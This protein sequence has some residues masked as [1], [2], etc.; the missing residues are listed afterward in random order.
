MKAF[1]RALAGVL[2]AA[3]LLGLSGGALAAGRSGDFTLGIYS[4]TDMN[5]KCYDLDPVTGREINNSYL[6][7]ASAMAREREESD[8]VLLLDNGGVLRGSSVLSYSL[9]EEG[10]ENP[11]ALCLR[12]CGYDAFIPG[13]HEFDFSPDRQEK[14]YETLA[15]GTDR[16]PGGPVEVLGAGQE[17]WAVYTFRADGKS[18]KVGVLGFESET[19]SGGEAGDGVVSAGVGLANTGDGARAY[20]YEWVN[21]R[22]KELREKEGCDLVVVCAHS[23]S[24][25]RE[26]LDP[27]TGE[28]GT[29]D[30]AERLVR[31]TTGVDLVVAGRGQASGVRSCPN[32]EGKTVPVVN[33][34]G[35]ALTKTPVTVRKDGTVTVGRSE[36]VDLT[37][38]RNDAGLKEWMEPYYRR[39]AAFVDRELGTL[40][41]RW[42][43]V[44]DLVHIQ[45]DTMDLVHEAQLW[46]TG[47]DVSIASPGALPDFCVGRLLEGRETGPIS[48]KDCCSICPNNDNRLYM[49][50]LTGRQLK[51]WLEDC[52][53]DYTVTESGLIG[54][55]DLG[56]D[57]VYGVSY[58]VYLGEP[59]GQRVQNLTFRGLPVTPGQ[60]FKAAVGSC[61]LSAN[62]MVDPYGWYAATGVTL[63]GSQVLWDAS[64]SEQFRGVGGSCTLILAEYIKSLTAAGKP[65]TP[66]EARSRWTLNASTGAE[67]M[68]KI[69]RLEFVE[70]LYEAAGKPT[71]YLDLTQTFS[72]ME[73]EDPA[74]AWAVQA[75]IVQG[76]GEGQFL[77]GVEVTREQAAVMLMRYD[78]AR[79]AGPVGAWAVRVPYT[80]AANVSTWAS[81][82]LMWNTIRDYLPADSGGN[83]RPQAVL[84]A[85]ELTG[86]IQALGK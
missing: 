58:D 30:R 80:D 85:G 20:A 70:R 26:A 33:G 76:N 10:G 13:E 79:G 46:A 44:T 8:A 81:E 9:A 2:S 7:V 32:A 59:E 39:T 72:D 12:Y 67:G 86:A 42:D 60:K 25:D 5:G 34:G 3:L 69:T 77:P 62:D 78:T 14:F 16:E 4:T 6:K 68:A 65:V 73:G 38:C 22:Q 56:T 27:V 47:A 55:G 51:D 48:L 64:Q 15:G 31:N 75:G 74:A 41:G 63:G 19:V 1:Q 28:A 29:E 53:K 17:P 61:R 83:F 84:T 54:G 43:D 21:E 18:F 35:T 50:E 82:A 52:A 37:V 24:G 49:V 71:A 66:P 57:Q 36:L 45:S 23:G 40:S 11:A